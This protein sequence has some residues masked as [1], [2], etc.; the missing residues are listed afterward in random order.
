[1]NEMISMKY[2]HKTQD[3]P[4]A[5]HQLHEAIS[6]LEQNCN[7]RTI[8]QRADCSEDT[9]HAKFR[10][11][12]LAPER[13][14]RVCVLVLG[15]F[16]AGKSTLINALVGQTVAATDTFEM[17]T[18]VARIIPTKQENAH[19]ILTDK[20][21]ERP[22][23]TMSLDEFIQFSIIQAAKLKSDNNAVIEGYT[24]ARIFVP[25]DLD[26]ELVD[27]P[28][29]GA[30]LDNEL[31]AVDAVSTCDVV[32]WTVDA[33]NIGGA[34]EAAMLEKIQERGQP[35]ICALTKS[36]ALDADEIL[37]TIEYLADSY[38]L[39]SAS[40]FAVSAEKYLCDKSDPGTARLKEH[41]QTAVVVKGKMIRERALLAQAADIAGEI[42]AC[43]TKTEQSI[44]EALGDTKENRDA[45]LA[46]AHN[47][48][49]RLCVE[50]ASAIELQLYADMEQYFT[51]DNA[52][53]TEEEIR[54]S[55]QRSM[56]SLNPALLFNH[57]GLE[58]IYQNLW[59][60]GIKSELQTLRMSLSQVR[61]E[62]LGQAVDRVAP[63]MEKQIRAGE[64][65]EK[66][67]Q[68]GLAAAGIFAGATT[69]LGANF[70]MGLLAAAP[71]IY[72]AHKAFTSRDQGNHEQDILQA[73]KT[74]KALF[75]RLAIDLI[76]QLQPELK[77]RNEQ[78]AT[79]ATNDFARK[80]NIWPLSFDELNQIYQKCLDTM[81]ILEQI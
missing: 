75:A 57:L 14:D 78:V 1:M 39:P 51:G 77:K 72:N 81:V 19:V 24:Q 40:I 74:T 69:V 26:A 38:S 73:T 61:Q 56:D 3:F 34:R 41:I 70:F 71:E 13:P 30:T 43:L 33:Q 7:D 17:T 11:G 20:N 32:L 18:A 5:L 63:V 62:A 47:V 66:A 80:N 4:T 68:H 10:I 42:I 60:D 45:F 64:Q 54:E 48:T 12:L 50:I 2:A 6:L 31:N 52:Y 29:L 49:D 15:E 36:D 46:M 58:K 8:A 53:V 35:L 55:L 25:S 79:E 76:K 65:R 28:G 44:G 59:L 27:T 21:N 23:K 16:K 22:V 9:A 37:P 67:V